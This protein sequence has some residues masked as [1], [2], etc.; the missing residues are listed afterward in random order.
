MKLLL[1]ILLIPIISISQNEISK[2]LFSSKDLKYSTEVGIKYYTG[3]LFLNQYK[4]SR[5]GLVFNFNT[6][7]K[8]SISKNSSLRY[9]TSIIL[10]N[11]IAKK[12]TI[13]ENI[14]EIGNINFTTK[15]PN[16]LS[17]DINFSFEIEKKISKVISNSIILKFRLYPLIYKKGNILNTELNS[18]GGLTSSEDNGSLAS[19]EKASCLNYSINFYLK[20]KNLIRLLLFVNSDWSLNNINKFNYFPGFEIKFEKI[21]NL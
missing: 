19:L 18:L 11:A 16:I 2:P 3:N 21:I 14:E 13:D 6:F 7:Y 15:I 20:K 1:Y 5:E 4:Y 17:F 12:I 9:T 8:K 10:S